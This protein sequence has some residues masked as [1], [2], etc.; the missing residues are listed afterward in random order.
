[1]L[2]GYDFLAAHQAVIDLGQNVIWM[3]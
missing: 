3:R 2:L 1:V